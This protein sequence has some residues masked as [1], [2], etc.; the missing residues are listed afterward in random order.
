MSAPGRSAA[1]ASGA[2]LIADIGGTN[3]RFAQ[4]TP[5]G[6]YGPVVRLR[7]DDYPGPAEAVHAFLAEADPPAPLDAAALA[8]ASPVAG[9]AVSM[10]NHP[11][12]FSI[13]AL[14]DSLGLARLDVVNDFA[15]VAHAV[16]HLPADGWRALGGGTP[17]PGT[18]VA[19]L[20]PGTGLGV[21][22]LVP[23][24]GQAAGWA[25]L[26]TEG[27]HVTM[28]PADDREAAVLDRLRHR[29]EHLSAERVVSGPGLAN[30]H[31]ALLE[32]AGMPG[33]ALEPAEISRRALDGSDTVCA[34][35]LAMFFA[36]LGTVAGNLALSLGARG[37][38]YLA[39]GI[40]PRM[41]DALA[42][43]DFRARFTA[44]GR[45]RDWLEAVPTRLITQPDPA[46]LGLARLLAQADPGVEKPPRA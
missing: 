11:W 25:V 21:S 28:P 19:L 36:M 17:A 10:T 30:L 9:D 26:A 29:F 8:V 16:P 27:G 33:A 23:R 24:A 7:C 34:E 37:G 44:K 39:G 13:A 40:L 42:A 31:E 4:A 12:R 15:A 41:A 32:L 3:A 20:G 14:R 6:G 5:D 45:F 38:V 18:P 43:S 1:P 46:L 22:A 35:A 2:R